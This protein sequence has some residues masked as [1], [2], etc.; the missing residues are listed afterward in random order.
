[1]TLYCEW[2]L[3]SICL[4]YTGFASEDASY[5]VHLYEEMGCEFLEKRN[6]GFSGVLMALR[7]EKFVLSNDRYGVNRNLLSRRRHRR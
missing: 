2:R 7:D 4:P 5:L 3:V 1:M 6:G